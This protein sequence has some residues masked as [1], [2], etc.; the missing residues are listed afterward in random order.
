MLALVCPGRAFAQTFPTVHVP[1]PGDTSGAVVDLG[2][3]VGFNPSGFTVPL[4]G[5]GFGSFLY[6]YCY[7]VTMNDDA[8]LPITAITA[9][10]VQNCL[11]SAFVAQAPTVLFEGLPYLGTPRP[12]LFTPPVF[13]GGNSRIIWSNS[14][15]G[16]AFMATWQ[17][18]FY[19]NVAPGAGNILLTGLRINMDCTMENPTLTIPYYGP[20]AGTPPGGGCPTPVCNAGGPYTGTVGV[21]VV[22]NASGSSTPA[23]SGPLSYVWNFGDGTFGTGV[24]PSHTYAA[25]GTYKVVLTVTNACGTSCTCKTTVVI[26]N[27]PQ[28][29]CPPPVCN[30]GGPYTGTVNN[31]VTFNGSGSSGPAPKTIVNYAWIFGDGGFGSGVMPTHVYTAPGTYTVTLFITNNCGKSSS[32]STTVTITRP[33]VAQNCLQE[34]K[35][36]QVYPALLCDPVAPFKQLG[37]WVGSD[38]TA[39]PKVAIPGIL[40]L[41]T[42][43]NNRLNVNAFITCCPGGTVNLTDV[44]LVKTVPGSAKY[45]GCYPAYTVTQIGP[46]QIRT[47]WNLNYTQPGTKFCLTLTGT[48]NTP[49]TPGTPGGPST[50]QFHGTPGNPGNWRKPCTCKPGNPGTPGSTVPYSDVWCWEVVANPDTF[51]LLID[52]FH[53]NAIGTSEVSCIPDEAVYDGLVLG[54]QTVKTALAAYNASKTVAN[55]IA[56]ID[57]IQSLEAYILVNTLSVEW[58]GDIAEVINLPPGNFLP[59][60]SGIWNTCENPCACKLLADLEYLFNKAGLNL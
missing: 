23:G 4:P 35:V 17:F 47:W 14:V 30:A 8:R 45:P 31:A 36:A 39:F 16:P 27:P 59:L 25:P 13:S 6:Q 18:C 49:G 3:T 9:F 26:T 55:R 40:S 48:C 42:L 51:I 15:G 5:G 38:V 52:L 21:P 11:S 41:S 2:L 33:P 24:S 44:R 43:A 37:T 29:V 1:F 19:S 50:C 22:F 7:T 58:L 12:E 53:S 46:E 56:A 32:C 34:F 57:A 28:E 54:A 20:C 10:E 60:G